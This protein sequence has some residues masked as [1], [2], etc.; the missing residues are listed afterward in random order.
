MYYGYIH[1]YNACTMAIV[2]A[3]SMTIVR[4]VSLAIV[5]ACTLAKVR[6]SLHT[7]RMFL[8]FEGGG[9]WGGDA[10]KGSRE[11]GGRQ[12]THM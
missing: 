12:V 9:F 2:H 4:A 5:H 3:G 8:A 11:N 6:V 7:G 1:I 10:P